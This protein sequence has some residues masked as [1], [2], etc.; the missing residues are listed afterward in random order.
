MDRDVYIWQ[1]RAE[2][3]SAVEIADEVGL[4]RSQV[5][6]I[7]AAA[8]PPEDDELD[9]DEDDLDAADLALL[10]ADDDD[11]EPVPPIRFVGIVLGDRN[12]KDDW[13]YVDSAAH[14]I[15]SLDLYRYTQELNNSGREAEHDALEADRNRQ[16][17]A[18]PV[19]ARLLAE[20]EERRLRLYGLTP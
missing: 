18:D 20:S 9:L 14:S 2:G 8:P 17:A 1:L 6:R 5:H 3:W 19:A 10:T 7:L 11:Y 4:S 15:S 13:R 12:R 16:Y